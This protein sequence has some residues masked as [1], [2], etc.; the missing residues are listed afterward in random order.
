MPPPW[1]RT[2]GCGTYIQSPLVVSTTSGTF[3]GMSVS[4][5]FD[6]W[7]GIPFAQPPV[8]SL[9]FKA[10]LP[11]TTP[12]P[13]VKNASTF[14]N[15]C[16]QVPAARFGVPLSED[17]LNLNVFRPT[18]ISMDEKLPVLVW[19]YGGGYMNGAASDPQFDPTLFMQRSVAIGKPMMFVTLASRFV[20]PE[21]LN[22]GLQD[23]VGALKFLKQNLAAFGGDASKSAG[24]GSVETHIL[25][26][27]SEPL[28]RAAIM[29][30]STGPF[31][32]DP[33][34]SRYDDPATGCPSGPASFAC[35][36]KVPLETLMNITNVFTS[37][38]LN[39]QFWQPAPGPPGS[40]ITERPS[41]R[42]LS[43][44]FLRV[45]ILAGTNLNEGAGFSTSVA[46]LTIPSDQED[47]RFDQ[48]IKD[49]MIDPT[50]ITQDLLD[51]IHQFYAANDSSLGAWYTD[52]MYLAPRRLL[53]SK[54]AAT[55]PIFAY[56]FKEF[57]PGED[58]FFGV[59]HGSELALLFNAFP[60]VERDFAN[61]MV[62]FYVS[63]VADL[64]PGV[65]DGN[66]QVLQL[67]RDNIT[68][69]PDDFLIEKTNFLSSARVLAEFQ[70]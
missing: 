10:P 32:N 1:K 41:Q 62:D 17:C 60:E 21:D 46:N 16:P 19:F 29:D 34:A 25:F 15:A 57:I 33:P 67:M 53:F 39:G 66:K 68:A 61:Q 8:G 20:P 65:H 28:F 55:Q 56:F 40:L 38:T 43:G 37:E 35:L 11:I 22:A 48:F 58:P 13:G 49:L 14:G 51:G 18:G 52:N 26:P 12:A 70:K 69:I 63:F 50:P 5:T 24:A 36:Q 44:N 7:L 3:S 23:Q 42:V 27:P 54:A 4:S 64:N 2:R 45:P 6:R 59:P 9:R 31:K 30:S 47:A